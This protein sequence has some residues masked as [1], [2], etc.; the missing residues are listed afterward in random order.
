MIEIFDGVIFH[1]SETNHRRSFCP[2][3]TLPN[4]A[5]TEVQI[6][7]A[8]LWTPEF[9]A[10]WVAQ[11]NPA[12]TLEDAIAAKVAEIKSHYSRLSESFEYQGHIYQSDKAAVADLTASLLVAQTGLLPVPSP[13]RTMDNEMV[14]FTSA[15]FVAFA[16]AVFQHKEGLFTE[17]VGHVDAVRALATV[18]AVQAYS[19]G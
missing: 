9:V 2:N 8:E 14:P 17:M 16:T 7:A 18:E 6:A 10:E 3:Q 19:F 12:P 13:W 15:E 1:Q 5:P 4:D 11:Q